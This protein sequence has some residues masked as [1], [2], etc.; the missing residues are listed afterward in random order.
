[1]NNPNQSLYMPLEQWEFPVLCIPGLIRFSPPFLLQ[2]PWKM[3]AWVSSQAGNTVTICPAATQTAAVA[4]NFAL[5]M[6]HGRTEVDVK[7]KKSA[8]L[9]EEKPVLNGGVMQIR[10]LLFTV[11]EADCSAGFTTKQRLQYHTDAHNN[12]MRYRCTKCSKGFRSASDRKRHE[13][14]CTL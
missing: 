14:T 2:R 13:R 7:R 1:M 4:S 12:I 11:S 6:D 8:L 10:H 9:Q 3:A 5:S